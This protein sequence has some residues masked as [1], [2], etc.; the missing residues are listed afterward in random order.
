MTRAH[1]GNSKR[2]RKSEG[3]SD[4]KN[5]KKHRVL[6]CNEEMLNKRAREKERVSERERDQR[7]DWNGSHLD[8]PLGAIAS[9][10]AAPYRIYE[11][12]RTQN[13]RELQ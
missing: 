4:R 3:Q 1:S 13:H 10:L 9:L 11:L 2:K 7:R 6:V 8:A 5:H 12:L